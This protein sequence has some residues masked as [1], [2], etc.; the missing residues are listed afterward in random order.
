MRR[1]QAIAKVSERPDDLARVEVPVPD[2]G[3]HEFLVRVRAIGVGIH[4]GYFL[5]ETMSFPYPIGIEAAGVIEAI[6][7]QVGRYEVGER[8]AFISAMQPKGGTWAEFAVVSD[9]SQILRIPPRM[10][11][12]EAAA[13]PVAGGTLLKAFHALEIEPGGSLF[14]AGASGAIGS[15]ATQLAV[16]QGCVVAGSAS[17]GNH[18][19]LRSLGA[20][21]AV[22]YHDPDW[23]EQIRRWMP[24]GVDRALAIPPKTAA[25]SMRTVKDGGCVVIVSGDQIAPERGIR[26]ESIPHHVD[27]TSEL[28][29]LMERIVKGEI[30]LSI[31]QVFPFE[32]GIAALEKTRT[33]HARG[34]VVI[35]MP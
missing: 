9:N 15:L 27:V 21:T 34:K 14:I 5:P 33:R 2:A 19:Y 28:G 22:D 24:G 4:D 23:V 30:R 35:A 18:A 26:T 11:F 16:V 1:M 12:I 8:I 13:L 32:E 10:S 17:P 3:D 7:G 31:E 25:E 6:G 29:R 20:A